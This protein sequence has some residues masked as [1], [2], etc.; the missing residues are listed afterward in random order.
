MRTAFEACGIAAFIVITWTS[1][2]M[3]RCISLKDG[4]DYRAA[5]ALRGARG[6]LVTFFDYGGYALWH[7]GPGL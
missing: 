4:P 7:F 2:M 6:R 1:G 5:E 3:P